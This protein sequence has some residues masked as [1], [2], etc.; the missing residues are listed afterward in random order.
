MWADA[1][2]INQSDSEEKSEAVQQ[3]KRIYQ[4]ANHVI[5]R[6]GP[7]DENSDVAFD[8]MDRIGKEACGIGFWN[9]PPKV[10]LEPLSHDSGPYTKLQNLMR[11]KIT[12]EYPFEAIG[13]LTRRPWWYRVWVLQEFVL[14]RE[15][16]L[17]CGFKSMTLTHFAPA[18]LTS[19][20]AL[21]KLIGRAIATP[22]DWMD[23]VKGPRMK[24]VL[25]NAPNSRAGN[26]IGARKKYHS[27][28]ESLETLIQLLRRANSVSAALNNIHATD[29][30]DR[31]FGMLGLA[32][33]TDKLEIR[34]DY[35]K[36]CKEVHVNAARTL[37]QHGHTDVLVF[38]QFPKH[39]SDWVPDWTTTIQEPCGGCVADAC[40]SASA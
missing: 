26:M 14:A 8:V 19:I 32:S 15:V 2:C 5:F 11:E 6:L 3:M 16:S 1:L 20:A 21:I 25:I 13:K 31:I 10:W 28:P 40:F 9:I 24:K 7:S 23:P 35:S 17:T 37:L 18:L 27:N 22:E 34:P 39:Y 30:R 12:F 4:D 29:P 33:D 38:S 36:P